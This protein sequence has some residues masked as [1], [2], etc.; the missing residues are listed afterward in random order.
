MKAKMLGKTTKLGMTT[1]GNVYRKVSAN[2]YEVSLLD[3]SGNVVKIR[4]YFW[5]D[6]VK[7][8]PNIQYW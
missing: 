4:V 1:T 3:E 8:F 2:Q 5:R 6:T 7:R